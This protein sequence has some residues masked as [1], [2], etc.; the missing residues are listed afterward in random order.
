MSETE[1]NSGTK[2]PIR[3][4]VYIGPNSSGDVA[5]VKTQAEKGQY[6]GYSWDLFQKCMQTPDM[7]EKY[8]LD[9]TY[10]PFGWTNH[11]QTIKDIA[12]G[13]YD[14]ASRWSS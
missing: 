8:T 10:S 1:I 14:I 4:L 3:A 5:H 13:Q 9:I 7:D 6:E 2:R 11:K 12:S